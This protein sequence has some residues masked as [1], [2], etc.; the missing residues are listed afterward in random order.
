[1]MISILLD[2]TLE[3]PDPRQMRPNVRAI[4]DRMTN[5]WRQAFKNTIGIKKFA[6]EVGEGEHQHK[7]FWNIEIIPGPTCIP[8]TVSLRGPLTLT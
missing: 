7:V 5:K 1:M 4:Y 8:K 3:F 2:R 6:F